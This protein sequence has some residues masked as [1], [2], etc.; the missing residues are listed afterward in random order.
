MPYTNTYQP[1]GQPQTTPKTKP[2]IKIYL[3]DANQ[4]RIEESEIAL[5]E[6][7]SKLGNKKYLS[8][9]DKKGNKY[10]GFFSK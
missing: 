1:T 6:N 3:K 8:G 4:K 2:A 9:K 7:T 5:W 10:V